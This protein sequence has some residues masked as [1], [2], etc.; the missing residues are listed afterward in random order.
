[1]KT[2]CISIGINI[3]FCIW[4]EKNQ[5]RT[6]KIGDTYLS[7]GT[8]EKD[9]GVFVDNKLNMSQQCEV[10]AKNANV[11]LGQINRNIVLKLRLQSYLC[12]PTSKPY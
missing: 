2:Q 11:I 6:Y 1:M 3:K 4:V 12:L 7:S 8:L 10:A 9:L 5:K